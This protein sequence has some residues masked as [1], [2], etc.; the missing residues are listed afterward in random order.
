MRRLFRIYVGMAFLLAFAAGM[1]FVLAGCSG[2]SG[3]EDLTEYYENPYYMRNVINTDSLAGAEVA[4]QVDRIYIFKEEGTGFEI[5]PGDV[6][7]GS[8]NGGFLREVTTVGVRDNI[9]TLETR[10]IGLADVVSHGLVKDSVR[11]S[12]GDGVLRTHDGIVVGD[13]IVTLDGLA[14]EGAGIDVMLSGDFAWEPWAVVYGDVAW[15]RLEDCWGVLRGDIVDESITAQISGTAASDS[16]EE[17]VMSGEYLEFMGFAGIIPIWMTV[18]Y[19]VYAG[20]WAYATV[21]GGGG[22]GLTVDEFEQGGS[23]DGS[24]GL[25]WDARPSR[26]AQHPYWSDAGRMDF[27]AWLR[28][29]AHVSID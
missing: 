16:V 26:T 11:L 24:W 29:E 23:Y 18:E 2:G 3:D 7:T 17:L 1:A 14:L 19:D 9:L 21:A 22:Y 10:P 25:F 27:R 5:K 13:G 4:A 20:A 6:V 12:I 8:A 15:F 28:A